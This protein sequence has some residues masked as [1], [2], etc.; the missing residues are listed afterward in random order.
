MVFIKNLPALQ[1]PVKA[2]KIFNSWLLTGSLRQVQQNND[3][4]NND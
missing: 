2:G 3:R 4:N 1:D